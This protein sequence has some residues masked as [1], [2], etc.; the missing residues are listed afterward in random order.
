MEWGREKRKAVHLNFTLGSVKQIDSRSYPCEILGGPNPVRF[1]FH[2]LGDCTTVEQGCDTQ[3]LKEGNLFLQQIEHP[4]SSKHC[5]KCWRYSRRQNRYNP[6]PH[7][8]HWFPL[9]NN[10]WPRPQLTK[11]S[12]SPDMGGNES[13]VGI[14]GVQDMS[15]VFK[16]LIV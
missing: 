13:H 2:G 14:K 8:V 3:L 16:D 12:A 10:Y 4:L 9:N 7:G 1:I 15:P 6:C 5:S 11:A